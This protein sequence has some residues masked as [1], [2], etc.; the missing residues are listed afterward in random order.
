MYLVSVYFDDKTN[1]RIQA[2]IDRVAE[3]TGNLYMKEAHVPPHL[4]VAAFETRDEEV[5]VEALGQAVKKLKSGEIQWTS[6]GQFFPYVLF[7]APVLNAYLHDISDA[8]YQTFSKLDG[9]KLNPNYLPF[10]W[11]PHT[12]IGKKL[13]PEEMQTAFE[14]M[15]KSFGVIEGKVIRIGLAKPNPHRDI[16][17]FELHE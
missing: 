10:H 1:R 12:T 15:Q 3:R 2:L 16:C 8:L 7:I 11:Q 5:A 13:T 14:T 17:V 6:V 9:A 4:T